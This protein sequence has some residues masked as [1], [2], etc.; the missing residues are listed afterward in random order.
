MNNNYLAQSRSAKYFQLAQE[1]RY[2]AAVDFLHGKKT[3]L[4]RIDDEIQI[5]SHEDEPGV[6]DEV[7]CI[8][9]GHHGS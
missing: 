7:L 2:R 9:N 5:T 1:L 6:D 4:T 8:L 3:T